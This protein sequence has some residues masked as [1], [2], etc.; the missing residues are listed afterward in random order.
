MANDRE[1]LRQVWEGKL[2][3]CFSLAEEELQVL[4][5]PDPFYL[6]VPRLA[7]FPLV[8]EK[9]R[10]QGLSSHLRVDFNKIKS[11]FSQ[12]CILRIK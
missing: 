4:Q 9:V 6:M 3:I 8:T 7:Y 11:V 12:K 1:V 10:I 5:T 2:P